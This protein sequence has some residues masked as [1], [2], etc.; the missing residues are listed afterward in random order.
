MSS[1]EEEIEDQTP[2][3]EEEEEEEDEEEV[4]SSDEGSE[5][6]D[7]GSDEEMIEGDDPVE[8]GSEGRPEVSEE[9][10]VLEDEDDDDDVDHVEPEEQQAAPETPE[11]TESGSNPPPPA[12]AQDPTSSFANLFSGLPAVS[13]VP[14]ELQ[15]AILEKWKQLRNELDSSRPR[16]LGDPQRGNLGKDHFLYLSIFRI[17]L[18]PFKSY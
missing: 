14:A 7:S 9:Q 4:L 13:E 16:V 3:V 2:E 10:L 18:K 15:S 8:V 5:Q 6:P 17:K 11:E 1:S 12:P